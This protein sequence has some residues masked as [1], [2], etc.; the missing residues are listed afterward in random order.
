MCGWGVRRYRGRQ[1]ELDSGDDERDRRL[2]DLESRVRR[3]GDGDRTRDRLM[4][5]ATFRHGKGDEAEPAR[6]R[7]R[8]ATP[9]QE[10]Q[11]RFVEGR[12][13]LTEYERELDRLERIE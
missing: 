2:A 9:L 6:M 7:E 13:T 12:L 1:R 11:Q 8:R 3:L 5:P 4:R 10:L